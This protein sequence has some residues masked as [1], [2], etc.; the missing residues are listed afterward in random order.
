MRLNEEL[1]NVS[2]NEILN[3][4]FDKNISFQIRDAFRRTCEEL[5]QT[6]KIV[7]EYKQVRRVSHSLHLETFH[8]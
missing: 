5:Q 6:Q 4:K 2:R 8:L 7:A 3:S 1:E